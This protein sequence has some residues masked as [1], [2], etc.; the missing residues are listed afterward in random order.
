VLT[1]LEMLKKPHFAD[2]GF[3]LNGKTLSAHLSV[4][5]VRCPKL[6]ERAQPKR[7]GRRV[8]FKVN[9]VDMSK[10]GH[11]ADTMSV[12]LQFLYGDNIDFGAL[13]PQV[14]LATCIAAHEYDL[15]R[16]V[17]LC[18]DHLSATINMEN[19]FG[20]LK[21]SDERKEE[22]VYKVCMN[23]AHANLKEFIAHKDRV[24]SLGMPLFQEVVAV[25]LEEYKALEADTSPVPE[26]SLIA[27]FHKMFDETIGNGSAQPDSFVTIE[28]QKL[29]FHKAILVAHANGFAILQPSGKLDDVTEQLAV[30]ANGLTADSFASMLR[31]IYY[32]LSD[33]SP[34]VAC[35]LAPYTAHFK[36]DSLQEI[37]EGHIA[38]NLK[39][40]NVLS[41]LGVAYRAEN[42]DRKDMVK[43]RQDGV[44]YVL[45][46]VGD[47]SLDPLR[48]MDIRIAVDILKGWQKSC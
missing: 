36:L 42:I 17:R 47:V 45:Q 6:A 11:T 48:T 19:V 7:R 20:L 9:T 35:N 34:L 21:T 28:G 15:P 29:F 25:G 44:D 33:V 1:H 22:T 18:H 10:S 41:V 46:N 26:S 13:N 14:V 38:T 16:L 30:V 43:L 5:Q 39:P 32:G 3:Q 40:D 8:F 12:V 2:V 4:L 23:F 27:D 24:A 31:Y 37:C